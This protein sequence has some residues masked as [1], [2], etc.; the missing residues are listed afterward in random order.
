MK[1]PIKS[2]VD[3]LKFR[4]ELIKLI[5]NVTTIVEFRIHDVAKNMGIEEY[6]EVDNIDS[7]TKKNQIFQAIMTK[8]LDELASICPTDIY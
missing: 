2:E 5:N 8:V 7:S 1:N 6:R 3:D 4:P